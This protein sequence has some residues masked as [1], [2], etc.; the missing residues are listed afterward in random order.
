VCHASRYGIIEYIVRQSKTNLRPDMASPFDL[1]NAVA[2]F[3]IVGA[4]VKVL[5]ELDG[6]MAD[7]NTQ[8]LSE[9][10]RADGSRIT[11]EYADFTIAVKS[12][13]SGLA[14]VTDHVTLFDTG[15]FYSAMNVQVSDDGLIEFKNDDPKAEKLMQRYSDMR[16]TKL[17]LSNK[18]IFGLTEESRIELKRDSLPRWQDEV[19]HATGLRFT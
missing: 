4:A 15:D 6:V 13:K 2:G 3:N 10:Q 14:G 7:L 1:R 9:G 16:H 12:G 17:Q 19:T 11:P 18:N 8:Q 5:Q